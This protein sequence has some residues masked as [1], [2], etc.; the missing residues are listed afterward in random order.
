M[1]KEEQ[2]TLEKRLAG[3]DKNEKLKLLKRAA[4]MRKLAQQKTNSRPK[5]VS[6]DLF[7]DEEGITVRS[8]RPQPSLNDWVLKLLEQEAPEAISEGV[9]AHPVGTVIAIGPRSAE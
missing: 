6:L 3:L 8:R 9:A 5:R 4:Q 7:D 2:N 1:T